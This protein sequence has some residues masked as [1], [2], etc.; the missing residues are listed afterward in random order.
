MLPAI[1]GFVYSKQ[2]KSMS[3]SIDKHWI[4]STDVHKGMLD[5]V[6]IELQLKFCAFKMKMK[7][8]GKL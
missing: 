8:Y 3:V 2:N 1:W 4:L 6:K 5:A 7:S